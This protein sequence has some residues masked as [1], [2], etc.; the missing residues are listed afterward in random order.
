MG[1]PAWGH[2]TVGRA[3]DANIELT[4]QRPGYGSLP[5]SDKLDLVAIRILDQH[6]TMRLVVSQDVNGDTVFLAYA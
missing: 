3:S 4:I 2:L 1:S 6:G 5:I